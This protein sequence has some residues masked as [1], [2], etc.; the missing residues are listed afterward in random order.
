MGSKKI[1]LLAGGVLAF[2]IIAL[3]AFIFLFAGR[4]AKVTLT[5]WGLWE[6]ESVF[7][8]VIAD[9]QKTHPNVTIKYVKQSSLNYRDRLT[10]ALNR[11]DGPDIIRM[12][13]SWLPSLQVGLAPVPSTVYSLSAYKSTFYP[14]ASA[15]FVSGGQIYAIPLEYDGLA[16]YVNDDIFRAGGVTTPTIWNGDGSFLDVAQK[17]TVRDANRRIKTAGAAIGTTNNVDH[18]QDIIG[19]MMLQAG[20]NPSTSANTDAAR[21]ALDYYTSFAKN[22]IWNETLDNSTL[23]FAKGQVAMIF[24]PSWTYFDIKQINPNLNFHVAPVPQLPGGAT[25]NYASY[26]GEAVSKRSKNQA[27]AFEFLKYL[28]SP[29]VLTKLYEAESKIRPF[30]EPY[31][32]T[33]MANLLATDPNVGPFVNSAPTAKSWY[34]ASGTTD[35]SGLNSK[36]A[37]Y[38]ADAISAVVGGDISSQA[39]MTVDKGVQQVLSQYALI[40]P[41]PAAK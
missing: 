29:A 2:L 35:N 25:V 10:T 32:R 6:P 5:Y 12:H 19:L 26:W 11:D 27:A 28:S 38:Y 31:S 41:Q 22:Q 20:V 9:Y 3:T 30:G 4:S 8:T 14:V 21:A 18:W 23:A 1:L 39:L 34:L 33:D 24:G 40:S 16:L 7:Q 13:N 36:L 17:L 37:S 15:N